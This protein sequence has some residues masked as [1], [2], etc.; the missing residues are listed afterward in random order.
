MKVTVSFSCDTIEDADILDWL[1]KQPNRSAAIREQI[2]TGISGTVRLIEIY[3]EVQQ[4]RQEIARLKTVEV[5]E[6]RQ[7]T[8]TSEPDDIGLALDDLGWN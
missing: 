8:S 3:Q 6:R 4:M 1:G 5:R 2:R 7:E